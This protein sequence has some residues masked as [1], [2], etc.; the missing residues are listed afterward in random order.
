MYYC[1][2]HDKYAQDRCQ[3]F[4]DF[5][6][7]GMQCPELHSMVD[8][9]TGRR[10][11]DKHEPSSDIPELAAWETRMAKWLTSVATTEPP[12]MDD[13]DFPGSI[14]S[15]AKSGVPEPE[16]HSASEPEPEPEPER[17]LESE[18]KHDTQDLEATPSTREPTT[19]GPNPKQGQD[20]TPALKTVPKPEPKPE[21]QL[22]PEH[23]AALYLQCNICLD[24]HSAADMNKIE[25]CG[26]QYKESCL[27]DFLR[28][29]GVRKY[30]CTGCWS[31]LQSHQDP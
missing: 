16:R 13:K 10:F 23:I 28:R 30:N 17:K 7:S 18:S 8:W 2:F 20:Q 11:C 1:S 27:Q 14:S 5:Q 26:H 22:Q 12:R 15:E 29:K 4:L 21:V 31:W 9:D 6:G 25:D 3:A 24:D 19:G